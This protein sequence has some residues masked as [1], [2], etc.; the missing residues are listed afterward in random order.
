M[1][2]SI[3]KLRMVLFIVVT[4]SLSGVSVFVSTNAVAATTYAGPPLR[5]PWASGSQ[6][7]SGNTY[8]C[9]DHTGKDQYAIDFGLRYVPVT[10]VFAGVIEL[11]A[12]LTHRDIT[13]MPHS[14]FQEKSEGILNLLLLSQK[15]RSRET[16]HQ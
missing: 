5:L 8:N 16:G 12:L 2:S 15:M 3:R 4:L 11:Q 14:Q 7:I 10:A 9:G 1:L 13:L 6:N